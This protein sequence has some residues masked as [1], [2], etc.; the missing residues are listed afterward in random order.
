[1]VL[2]K[3]HHVIKETE[4]LRLNG[5]LIDTIEAQARLPHWKTKFLSIVGRE[6]SVILCPLVDMYQKFSHG[7][8]RNLKRI[9]RCRNRI[10]TYSCPHIAIIGNDAMTSTVTRIG[11]ELEAPLQNRKNWLDCLVLSILMTIRDAADTRRESSSDQ[12]TSGRKI[13]KNHG[14]PKG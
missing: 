2:K 12:V 13:G 3:K 4:E 1:L 9:V 14:N 6:M 8:I 7:C 11:H 10:V 5:Q